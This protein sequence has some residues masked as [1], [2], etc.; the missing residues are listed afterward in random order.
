MS[1]TRAENLAD[2]RILGP[3]EMPRAVRPQAEALW[4]WFDAA[5]SDANRSR[6]A[7]DAERIAS[8]QEPGLDAGAWRAAVDACAETGLDRALLAPRLSASA[9]LAGSFRVRDGAELAAFAGDWCGAHARLLAGLAG[10]AG[11]WQQDMA[12]DLARGFFL[13][14]SVIRAPEHASR[15]WCFIPVA[16][17]ERFDVA[18]GAL[19]S[20][21]PTPGARRLLWRQAVRARDALAQGR[22]L[23]DE[24]PAL[25]ALRVRRYW[26][27]A[28]ELLLRAEAAD[29]DVWAR[30]PTVGP[31][32]RFR[33]HLQS[34]A[35][36]TAFRRR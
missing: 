29:W 13:T 6:A 4:T 11:S 35:G 15:D 8:G 14:A 34:I 22:P 19:R 1:A 25:L 31:L 26:F 3:G 7:E 12:S 16:D 9:R 17:L 20:G 32:L 30:P 23:I 33:V 18:P 2:V 28:L 27:G 36:R 24:M 5:G 10:L 21:P